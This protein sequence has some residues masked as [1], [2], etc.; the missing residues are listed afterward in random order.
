[1]NSH[2]NLK[3]RFKH[4]IRFKKVCSSHDRRAG[5]ESIATCPASPARPFLPALFTLSNRPCALVSQSSFLT[6]FFYARIIQRDR[7]PTLF[8]WFWGRSQ[9][10]SS[11]DWN[12]RHGP[13][14]RIE[15]VWCAHQTATWTQLSA[16]L[17]PSRLLTP[18][19]TS[20]RKLDRHKIQALEEENSL[21]PAENDED[22]LVRCIIFSERLL[23]FKIYS[24]GKKLRSPVENQTWQSYRQDM[25]LKNHDI[26][27]VK[28]H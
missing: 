8:L 23:P 17:Q 21:L 26:F 5:W 4:Y 9:L 20:D 27:T 24:R 3:S 2:E 12:Q 6:M 10:E 16:V 13:S 11:A 22:H 25:L 1:M 15:T 18:L 7:E 19:R 14:Q 28:L